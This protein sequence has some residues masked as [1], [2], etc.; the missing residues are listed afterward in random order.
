[1]GSSGRAEKQ[2]HLHPKLLGRSNAP[3]HSVCPVSSVTQFLQ[4]T[5]RTLS[6][7]MSRR[8][9]AVGCGP[10]V[11]VGLTNSESEFATVYHV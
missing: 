9:L 2:P 6:A 4:I 10:G 1:M 3:C 7:Y 5:L 8:F 11:Y